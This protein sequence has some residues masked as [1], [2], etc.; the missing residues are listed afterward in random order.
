MIKMDSKPEKISIIGLGYVGLP[1]ALA[2]SRHYSV[3]GFDLDEG[4]VAS[5]TDM[6]ERVRSNGH[7]SGRRL[8]Y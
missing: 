3:V 4:R 6:I 8:S 1:L 2:L 7:L 5:K